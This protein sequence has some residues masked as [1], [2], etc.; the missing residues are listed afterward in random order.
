MEKEKILV[1]TSGGRTSA[2]LAWYFHTY[3]SEAFDLTFAYAN[4][5]WEHEKT[6]EFVR[7][8]ELKMG[9]PIVWLE[10]VVHH[11]KRKRSTYR[12][13]DFETASRDGE[14]F[15]EMVKKYGLPNKTYPHCTRELKIGPMDAYMKDY[16][17][18]K[19]TLGIR[20]DEMR[21][22]KPTEEKLYPLVDWFPTT[23]ED[24]MRFW[25]KQSFNLMIPEHLG[26]CLACIKKSDKKLKTI[27]R[28]YPESFDVIS[29][30]EKK[31]S[32][33]TKD[34]SERQVYRG[35]LTS[36]DILKLAQGEFV[37]FV[38]PS[39]GDDDTENCSEECGMVDPEYTYDDGGIENINGEY[40][41]E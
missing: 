7:D 9:I 38:D 21:R 41:D 13:V 29:R 8:I 19:K 24:V 40:K 15:E 32:N 1:T 25:S 39:W 36:F 4:T 31:Y 2:Y 27:A 30:L 14:P 5:G 17:I 20:C 23:K 22:Y 35:Y 26:N 3:L 11:G 37:D 34:G 33:H 28:D 10:A 18:K 16:G 6:L 12:I